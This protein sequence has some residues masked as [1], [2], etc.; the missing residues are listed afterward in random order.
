MLLMYFLAEKSM[1]VC[2]CLKVSRLFNNRQDM[3]VHGNNYYGNK[4][5]GITLYARTLLDGSNLYRSTHLA[6]NLSI[7]HRFRVDNVHIESYAFLY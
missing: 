4:F 1:H 7:R 2:T 6:D 5:Y 3:H